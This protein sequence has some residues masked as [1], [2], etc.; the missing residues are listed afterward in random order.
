MKLAVVGSRNYHDREFA[1]DVLDAYRE[2]RE[3][4]SLVSGGAKGADSLATEYANIHNIPIEVILPDWDKHGK[5]AGFIRNVDIWNTSDE[6]VA[7]WDGISKGTEHS[8]GL[9][10]KQ[11]KMLTI[12]IG[13]DFHDRITPKNRPM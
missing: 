5:S 8:F 1:F 11:G 2:G 4:T 6:G 9:A 10:R 7:F 13:R 12:F 3:I